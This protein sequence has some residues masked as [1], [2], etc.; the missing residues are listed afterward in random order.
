MG[1][2]HRGSIEPVGSGG[3]PC[4]PPPSFPSGQFC[5]PYP[6]QVVSPSTLPNDLPTQISVFLPG[7]P[8]KQGDAGSGKTSPEIKW[9]HQIV[10]TY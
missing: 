4:L 5:L 6:S 2:G 8:T 9:F 10:S 1:Q 3:S 7:H